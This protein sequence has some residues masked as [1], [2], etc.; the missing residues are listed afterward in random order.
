[1]PFRLALLGDPRWDGL[2][3]AGERPVALL[4]ALAGAWPD[5]VPDDALVDALWPAQTPQHPAKAL[6][7][8]V[9]R[10]RAATAATVVAR[11]PRGYR[12]GLGAE[13]VDVLA[14]HQHAVQ[15]VRLLDSGDAP[16]AATQALAALELT[17]PEAA[18]GALTDALLGAA[19][20]D[21]DIATAVAGRALSRCGDHVAALD[22]LLRA[23][24]LRPDDE[25]LLAD[26]LRSEAVVVGAPAALDR[27]ARYRAGLAERLGTDPGPAL[28][29]VHSELLA[30]DRPQRTGLRFASGPLV[31]RQDDVRAVRAL[32]ADHR[33]VSV[34]GAGGLGKTTL[35]QV[36][37]ATAEQPVV[38]V[39][40]LV[41]VTS[42][43]E[44]LAEVA[45]TLGVEVP[46]A[47]RR[48][49]SPAFRSDVRAA[50]AARLAGAPT[51]LVLDNCEHVLDGVAALVAFLV[52]SSPRLRVLTTSRAPLAIAAERVFL[53][54]SLDLEQSAELF[55]ERAVAARPG[56]VL[57]DG[58]VAAVVARLDGLP[59]AIELAAARVRAMSVAQVAE[60]LADRFGLLQAGR[61][62][63]DRHRTLLAV[64]EWSWNLL[65]DDARH[66]LAVLATFQDG[67][68]LDAAEAMLGPSALSAVATL[69]EQSLLTVAE[70]GADV[71]YR[72]LETIREFGLRQLDESGGREQAFAAHRRWAVA[73][74]ERYG[75]DLASPRMLAAMG[76]LAA[77]E[78]N[79]TDAL[80]RALGDGDLDATV[81]LAR[82]LGSM[83][84][85]AEHDSRLALLGAVAPLVVGASLPADLVDAAREVLCHALLASLMRRGEPTK[86][87]LEG[88]AEL[89]PGPDPRVAAEVTVL[90]AAVL[91]VGAE[92]IEVCRRLIA[93]GD[94]RMALMAGVWL[95]ALLEND[96]DLAGAAQAATDAR[97]L[98]RAADGP[99]D[100]MGLDSQLA[101][102]AFNLGDLA[103][104]D[105]AA[106]RAVEPY[107]AI[108]AAERVLDLRALLALVALRRGDPAPARDLVARVR[109]DHGRRAHPRS[110]V[111][112]VMRS[113]LELASGDREASARTVIEVA[114]RLLAQGAEGGEELDPWALSAVA[115]AVNALAVLGLPRTSAP[116]GLDRDTAL[117]RARTYLA[118]Q[119]YID[120]PICGSLLHA[121]AVHDVLVEP[122]SAPPEVVA[123]L[124]AIA[125][126]W[127]VRRWWWVMDGT[128]AQL[129]LER[130][131]PGLV[132]RVR[133]QYAGRRGAQLREEASGL[134]AQL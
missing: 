44:V 10:V 30:A 107:E 17:V 69:V 86:A 16:G 23:H 99:A 4:S 18:T 118:S 65:D 100:A 70:D 109:E 78:A 129:V 11:T 61:G 117:A 31:G 82:V 67:F 8:V 14:L 74:A 102:Y 119:E 71:R 57:D 95:S 48:L 37:A 49:L 60:R 134:L 113:E 68:T 28:V 97:A 110:W 3:F 24:E 84:R 132:E 116:P 21:R 73:V 106:R 90:S 79:L 122:T 35:A 55:R 93:D 27:Y 114:T 121:I 91:G 127:G 52:A 125:Q 54:G 41:A 2:P 7:L 6:Q 63:P 80:R 98:C 96:G 77:E 22:L 43:D 76:A 58:A 25:G 1:M 45:T 50:A 108:G 85:S 40:E 13:E 120:Y 112:E 9:S 33:V 46:A 64:I 104:A 56:V 72:A 94:R 128:A 26:L 12:L 42:S 36:V 89:G 103:T 87:V 29:Q 131:S 66:A 19:G 133:A 62:T 124:L 39:V 130:T 101:M 92:A 83:W 126:A 32:L 5:A 20:R 53:L 111:L 105:A 59:L 123:R 88:L 15:A 34:V 51:L 38:H 47:G 75:P 81:R 115:F